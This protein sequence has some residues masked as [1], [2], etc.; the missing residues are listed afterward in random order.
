MTRLAKAE[1]YFQRAFDLD[2]IIQS[3]D[4]VTPDAF[5]A[6]N[7]SLFQPDRYALTTIGHRP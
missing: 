6:L 2:E 4:D 3:I 1:I 5:A 7:R